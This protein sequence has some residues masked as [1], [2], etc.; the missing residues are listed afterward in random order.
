M[1]TENVRTE[2]G[3]RLVTLC[4]GR[5]G[6]RGAVTMKV[7]KAP[8]AGAVLDFVASTDALD[9]FGEIISPAGWRLESYRENPVFQNA[10][11]YGDIIFTLGKALVTEVREVAGRPALFQRVEFAV[12]VNPLARVAYG[13][14]Q[15]GFL[16]A[17]SVGFIPLRWENGTAESGFHR[18]YLEQELLEVSAV[19]IPANPQA[20]Q[21]ALRAGAVHQADVRETAAL[22]RNLVA[23]TSPAPL[24][25][26]ARRLAEALGTGSPRSADLRSAGA[27][28]SGLLERGT[29]DVTYSASQEIS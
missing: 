22:L 5:E 21:L 2:F 1:K 13:L 27:Q 8:G 20:L 28:A 19:P 25:S 9:R 18:R 29:A 16:N 4:D 11:Q 26:L 10:H 15:G 3:E 14:Y 23:A 17:V 6:L 24:Q 7:E 12:E